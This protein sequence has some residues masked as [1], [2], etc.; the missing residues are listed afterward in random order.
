[1]RKNILDAR[2]KHF[3]QERQDMVGLDASILMNPKVWEASGHVS[4][5]SDP[6]VDCRKCK[7]RDRADKLIEDHIAK[8]KLTLDEIQSKI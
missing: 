6:L 4:S 7:Y 5:F 8:N 2:W 1:L 3:V